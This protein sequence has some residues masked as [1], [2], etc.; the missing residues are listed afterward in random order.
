[1]VNHRR[2][3]GLLQHDF[4]KPN[5]VGIGVFSPGQVALVGVVPLQQPAAKMRRRTRVEFPA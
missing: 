3:A 5:I 4:R 2:N 1:M